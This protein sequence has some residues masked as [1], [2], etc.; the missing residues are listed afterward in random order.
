MHKT[1]NQIFIQDKLRN[2]VY[3]VDNLK[4]NILIELDIL[5]LQKINI[6]YKR[7]ILELN[8]CQDITMSIIV[9]AIK[10]K[11]KRVIRTLSAIVISTY[12]STIIFIRLR[13]NVELSKDCDFMFLL[14]Q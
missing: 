10:D 6:N 11:I 5:D 2:Q 12:S 14:Y 9:I 13:D 1:L 7:E 8:Y 3:V 4:T